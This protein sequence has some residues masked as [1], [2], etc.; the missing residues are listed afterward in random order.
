MKPI[1]GV[2]QGGTNQKTIPTNAY[3]FSEPDDLRKTEVQANANGPVELES[4]IEVVKLDVQ[5]KHQTGEDKCISPQPKQKNKLDSHHIDQQGKVSQ[6][7]EGGEIKDAGEGQERVA[8]KTK[9][10]PKREIESELHKIQLKNPQHA[11]LHTLQS[12]KNR[13]EKGGKED[14]E[15]GLEASQASKNKESQGAA[16]NAEPLECRTFEAE[17]YA[18]TTTQGLTEKEVSR[19]QPIKPVVLFEPEAKS[20]FRS[21]DIDDQIKA[22][23][24]A[25]LQKKEE[26]AGNNTKREEVQ[27]PAIEKNKLSQPNTFRNIVT[28][29]EDSDEP[30][31]EKEPQAIQLNILKPADKKKVSENEEVEIQPIRQLI[32]EQNVNI[33][34]ELSQ[35]ESAKTANKWLNLKEPHQENL[36]QQQIKKNI[37]KTIESKSGSMRQKEI[38]D[39]AQEAIQKVAPVTA[40]K[41]VVAPKSKP[42]DPQLIHEFELISE[43]EI[44]ISEQGIGDTPKGSESTPTSVLNPTLKPKLRLKMQKNLST[45]HL[46]SRRGQSVAQPSAAEEGRKKQEEQK[47]N[48][49]KH[50]AEV[51]L[52][53]MTN[54]DIDEARVTNQEINSSFSS[55]STTES[56]AHKDK[57]LSEKKETPIPPKYQQ[58]TE[59]VESV[60]EEL[61][62]RQ[63][64]KVQVADRTEVGIEDGAK[65]KFAAE[66]VDTEDRPS[67][68]QENTEESDPK[69]IEKRVN[70][71]DATPSQPEEQY[72]KQVEDKILL[73]KANKIET[74]Q[75]EEEKTQLLVVKKSGAHKTADTVEVEELK[76]LL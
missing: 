12:W 53:K 59:H 13:E 71:N 2:V 44:E 57:K 21:M 8:R 19:Q 66:V 17:I 69:K 30:Y 46:W 75:N 68:K 28:K 27:K 1:N 48:Q 20:G 3:V 14:N 63:T 65:I 23:S 58:T 42:E 37:A 31:K 29:L 64:F 41:P 9:L 47:V 76:T 16:A 35:K 34:V 43:K 52:K 25:E 39:Q 38:G 18:K 7:T 67:I 5:Q 61:I 33:E 50:W 51:Q 73:E 10:G 22:Q 56:S 70:F 11:D 62:P 36:G 32:K 45:V 60:V 4:D 55:T 24:S 15:Y 6:T 74:K 72:R 54:I 26:T 40:P 49:E